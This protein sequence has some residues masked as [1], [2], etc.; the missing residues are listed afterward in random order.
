[1][2]NKEKEL[3]ENIIELQAKEITELKELV[4]AQKDQIITLTKIDD[5]NKEIIRIQKEIIEEYKL[6]NSLDKITIPPNS[7][8]N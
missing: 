7:I 1:M 8:L 4:A 2:N 6:Q 5:N 3:M